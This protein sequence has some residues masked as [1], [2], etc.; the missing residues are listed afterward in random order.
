MRR[1]VF[2]ILI[3]CGAMFA[4]EGCKTAPQPVSLIFDTDLGPDYDDVGALTILHALA[5]SGEV[6]ILATVSCNLD[7]LVAPDIDAINTY[8]GRPDIP[9]GA[10]KSGGVNMGD[11]WHKEKWTEALAAKYPHDL[12][13]TA[14]APDAVRVYREILSKAA[15]TSVVIVTV[16]FLTNLANLMTTPPDEFSPLNGMDL[17][18]KKVHHLVSMAGDIPSGREFNV[19]CDSTASVKVFNEWPTR[20]IIS[21]SGPQGIGP[22]ILTG[23]QLVASGIA[24]TPAKTVFTLCLKQGDFEGRMSWDQTAAL[25]GVRGIRDYFDVVKGRL[26]VAPD[27]SNTWQDDPA[28]THEC[29]KFKMT[30]EEIRSVIEGMMM[31]EKE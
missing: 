9:I 19:F 22:K 23:K 14:D 30:P 29:L 11:H 6:N 31:H 7:P 10:P 15:D 5:D 20:I 2:L 28:G 25:V 18:K 1:L 27:G 12:K 3:L 21:P 24:E 17:I 16:G 4:F 8:F 26:I 13:S